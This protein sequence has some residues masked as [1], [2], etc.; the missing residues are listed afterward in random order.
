MKSASAPL[1]GGAREP[2][3]NPLMFHLDR[4]NGPL[5]LTQRHLHGCAQPA[6]CCS[7]G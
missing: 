1:R 7:S 2:E 3:G 6:L 4:V 5:E